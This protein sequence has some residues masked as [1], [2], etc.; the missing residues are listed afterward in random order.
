MYFNNAVSIM[1]HIIKPT[2]LHSA[3]KSNRTVINC[4]NTFYNIMGNKQTINQCIFI[5]FTP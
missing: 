1:K 4:K 5:R 3:T 2:V